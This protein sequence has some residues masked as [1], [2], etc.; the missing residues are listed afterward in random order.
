MLG[1]DHQLLAS[2]WSYSDLRLLWRTCCIFIALLLQVRQPRKAPLCLLT[3]IIPSI[4]NTGCLRQLADTCAMPWIKAIWW[5]M[6]NGCETLAAIFPVLYGSCSLLFVMCRNVKMLKAT[7]VQTV[8][9][10]ECKAVEKT[11]PHT[12]SNSLH[13]AYIPQTAL[14]ISSKMC[15]LMSLPSQSVPSNQH[16]K[17][18]PCYLA[19]DSLVSPGKKMGI[20]GR[21]DRMREGM[22][23]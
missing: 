14:S 2:F 9:T 5:Q 13:L 1:N 3:W 4:F 21:L 7:W 15:A 11:R 17:D 6:K 20:Q 16:R 22:F 18:S 10:W 19:G 12:Y 23:G 8:M